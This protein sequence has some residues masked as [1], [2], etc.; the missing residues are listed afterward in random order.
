MITIQNIHSL[1]NTA[2]MSLTIW[3]DS[4]CSVV[5]G[6]KEYNQPRQIS[7]NSMS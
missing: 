3:A 2:I 7:G 1:I 4:L 6:A 5:F